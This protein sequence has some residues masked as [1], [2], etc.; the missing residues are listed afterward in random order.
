MYTLKDIADDD[1]KLFSLQIFTV[2]KGQKHEAIYYFLQHF[3]PKIKVASIFCWLFPDDWVC[4][5]KR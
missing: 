1:A 4:I 5:V 3:G 2:L